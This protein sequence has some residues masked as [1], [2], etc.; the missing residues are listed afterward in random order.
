MNPDVSV[1]IPTYNRMPLLKRALESLR[2]QT[3][4]KF[5]ALIVDDGSSDGTLGYLEDLSSSDDRFIVVEKKGQP[6]GACI[7]RNI[8]VASARGTYVTGLDDD[9][10]FHPKRLEFLL[11]RWDGGYSAITTNHYSVEGHRNRRS[12]FVSRSINLSD[13]LLGNL[14]GNQV[15]TLRERI[16]SVGGFDEQLAAS[17]DYDLWIRLIDKYGPVRRY[18]RPLYFMDCSPGRVRISTSAARDHG[19]DQIIRKYGEVM[20]DQQ[21]AIRS[22]VRS[23]WQSLPIRKKL[24]KSLRFGPRFYIERVRAR[25]MLA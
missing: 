23:D 4:E 17:Q 10:W 5:E 3:F 22:R 2:K 21:L 13:M 11:Q 1:Y 8:A 7:S 15:F 20:T 9:D 6:R 25:L 19:T 14:V 18:S 24:I 16:L 12:S